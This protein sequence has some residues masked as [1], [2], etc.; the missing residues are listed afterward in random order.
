MLVSPVMNFRTPW[1]SP[2]L[3]LRLL[4]LTDAPVESGV[5]AVDEVEVVVVRDALCFDGDVGGL[6]SLLLPPIVFLNADEGG[7]GVLDASP[8][9]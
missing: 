6:L 2:I 3:E 4:G 7:R 9:R 1:P 5:E 8:L